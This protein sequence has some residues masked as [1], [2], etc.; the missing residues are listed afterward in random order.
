MLSF[1]GSYLVVII[2]FELQ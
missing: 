1:V 2:G